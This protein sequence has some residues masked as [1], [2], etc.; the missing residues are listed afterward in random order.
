M[1]GHM[2]LQQ[3]FESGVSHHQAGRVAEAEAIYRQ[4]LLRNP[5]HAEALHLLGLIAGQY[6]NDDQAIDL[7]GRAIRLMP[8]LA[9]AHSNLGNSLMRKGQLDEAVASY[10]RAIALKPDYFA[11]YCNLAAALKNQGHLDESIAAAN[12]AIQLNPNSA[13]AYNNL[14]NA[15]EKKGQF[16]LAIAAF[17]QAAQL[18]PNDGGAYCNLG[19]LMNAIGRVDQAIPLCRRAVQ[20]QPDRAEAHNNLGIA[21]M[22]D[23]QLDEADA[24]LQRAVQLKPDYAEALGNLG[25]VLKEKGQLE[26]AIAAFRRAIEISPANAVIHSNLVH[27]VYFHPDYGQAELLRESRAW[28]ARHA[29]PLQS[30]I[31]RHKNTPDPNRRLRIGYVSPDFRGHTQAFFTVPLFAAHDSNQFE[32]FC[33]S[34]V[35]KPDA[36]TE[37]LRANS[38]VWRSTVGLSDSK[39]ADMVRS[40]RIDILVD[41]TMHMAHN[42]LPVFARK[43]A[44]VQV[45]W[46]AYP[47][48][49]G[50]DTIDYRLT[51]PY[52]DPPQ[53]G[54]EFYTEKSIRLPNAFW[55]YDPMSAET[56]SELPAA[57]NGY[58]TFGSLNNFCKVGDGVLALW[59]RLLTAVPDSRLVLLSPDGIHRRQVLEKLGV[60]PARV[61][62]VTRM[63]RG[64]YLQTHHRFDIVLDTFPSNGHTTSLDA[65]WMGVPVV[66]LRGQTAVG[67]GGASILSNVGLTEFIAENPEQYLS[68]AVGLAGDLPKLGE[69]RS[70]LRTR[71]ERS[72]LMNARQFA[73]DIEAA[74]RQMWRNWCERGLPI[75]PGIKMI[76][77]P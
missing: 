41:L 35:A 70:S 54:D 47:G 59:S 30:F 61:E 45:T 60:E 6:G 26:Q 64:R 33:Y 49:T 14:G 21:L 72:P 48:T 67:R 23:G 51:D 63:S 71:I 17:G 56:V 22:N 75:L 66:T 77:P 65:L 3:Q 69:L 44:P 15:L 37:R 58:V 50:L 5:N 36:V 4:V 29:Q 57:R 68:I 25:M 12:R 39:L 53:T 43:P 8:G 31:R 9:N 16:G 42:R 38:S 18:N 11:A 74:Y 19:G 46:L 7:I 28:A 1:S 55:C 2:T 76:E 40:D 62:F 27:T 13:E 20:L 24:A 34:D 10:R 32:I 52:L 73:A